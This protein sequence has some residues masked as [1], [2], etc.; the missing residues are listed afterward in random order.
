MEKYPEIHV[1]LL[2]IC[3]AEEAT[4]ASFQLC[5]WIEK[6]LSWVNQINLGGKKKTFLECIIH[7]ELMNI[8]IFASCWD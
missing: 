3:A 6:K 8:L 1:T 7:F 5:K 2:D 4:L